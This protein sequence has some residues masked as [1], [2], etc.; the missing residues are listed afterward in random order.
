MMRRLTSGP[1]PRPR[2][3]RDMASSAAPGAWERW[4]EPTAADDALRGGGGVTG[5]G[6]VERG[7]VE[8]IVAGDHLEHEGGVLD[9]PCH[10]SDL[11]E[12]RRERDD[13]VPRHPAVGGL[14]TDAP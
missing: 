2:G 8:R 5:N 12:R 1:K 14:Q 13:A 7:R 3:S 4:P 11:I 9:G 10:R 6:G